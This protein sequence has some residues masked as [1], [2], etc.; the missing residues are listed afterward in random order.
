[1]WTIRLRRSVVE[2]IAHKTELLEVHSEIVKQ[3]FVEMHA[4]LTT[5]C[6]TLRRNKFITIILG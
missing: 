6:L 2:K 4:Y 5:K 3:D 1:M